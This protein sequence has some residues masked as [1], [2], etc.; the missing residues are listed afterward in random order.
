MG[1]QQ[2]NFYDVDAAVD[3]L[4]EQIDRERAVDADCREIAR[5][6]AILHRLRADETE[7]VRLM[8]TSRHVDGY[9]QFIDV[10]SRRHRFT[11]SWIQQPAARASANWRTRTIRIAPIVDHITFAIALHETG[12][13]LAGECPE[14]EPHRRDLGVPNFWNCMACEVAAWRKA[15]QVSPVLTRDMH[16]ILSAAL[17]T[18][19]STPAS[20]VTV[21]AL[22]RLASPTGYVETCAE[23]WKQEV[24]WQKQQLI[25]AT[26]REERK[27]WGSR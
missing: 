20:A 7:A 18:Y 16:R 11:V 23:R 9:K 2:R 17:R 5:H 21:R 26:L 14:V 1:Y 8:L 25:E 3:R 13:L 12:H 6:A 22:D 4:G 19:R 10:L 27:R 15:W 24:F